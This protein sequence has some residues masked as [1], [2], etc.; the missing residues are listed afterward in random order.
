MESAIPQ[1]RLA[2]IVRDAQARTGISVAA[3]AVHADGKTAVAGEHRRPFRIA[4]IT[5]SFTATA[6]SL[7]GLLDD[8]RRALLSHTAGY[9]PEQPEPLPPECT[10]LWSYSNAGYREAA[11]GFDGDYSEAVRELVLEP[12]GLRHTGFDVPDDAVLGTLPGKVVADPAYPVERRPAGGLWST[13]GDLVEYGRA[14]CHEWDELHQP[15][16]DALGARYALGWWVRDGWLDH[17][18][19]VGGFQSLL[20]LVPEREVV[21]AVLTN[22]WRGSG[23]IRRVV[24]DLGLTPPATRAADARDV[25]GT[26]SLDGLEAV[27]ARG[28]VT[29]S[30]TD[31]VTGA[32]VERRYRLSSDATLM[33][34][35]SDFPRPG[36]ARVG[37]V[38]LPRSSF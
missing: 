26:Y 33:T 18:G 34:W 36:V 7:A 8:H 4:S 32:R 19:S 16:A 1:E 3:A 27:V 14:H 5:K 13:V 35:R 15:V 38:S 22:S 31:P 29:E 37:W 9:R 11:S 25:E 6:I 23:L 21:L 24:E 30:E 10:G 2:E 28:S 12:L 17:E 20:M